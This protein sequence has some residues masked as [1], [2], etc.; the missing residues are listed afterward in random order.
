M[1]GSGTITVKSLVTQVNPPPEASTYNV[2]QVPQIVLSIGY[3]YTYTPVPPGI[4]LKVMKAGKVP[5]LLF[6]VYVSDSSPRLCT[7]VKEFERLTP[8]S[9]VGDE[10][11]KS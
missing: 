6:N 4:V 5:L 11:Q 7:G 2:S 8:T 1:Q 9:T 3:K 10:I